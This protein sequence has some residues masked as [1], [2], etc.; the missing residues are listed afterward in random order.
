VPLD[1]L[2]QVTAI[3]HR[4]QNIVIGG[5]QFDERLRQH[6]MIIHQDNARPGHER[7]LRWYF[8]CAS[9]NSICVHDWRSAFTIGNVK[10]GRRTRGP[11]AA[12]QRHFGCPMPGQ[13]FTYE[14]IFSRNTGRHASG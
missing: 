6:P 14:Y 13:D 10:P 2:D 12:G 11:A 3:G 1:R 9:L 5:E 8:S 4:I 7:P